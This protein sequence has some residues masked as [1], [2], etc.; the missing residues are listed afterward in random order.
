MTRRA[1]EQVS[2]WGKVYA[3]LPTAVRLPIKQQKY[4]RASNIRQRRCPSGLIIPSL[5]LC[6]RWRGARRSTGRGI[7]TVG[8]IQDRRE[9]GERPHYDEAMIKQRGD[10]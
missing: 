7:P 6:E 1:R 2:G 4:S 5:C 10:V 9:I 8:Q 3:T